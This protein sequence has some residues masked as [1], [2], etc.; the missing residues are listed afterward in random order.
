MQDE[1]L[2]VFVKAPQL[3]KVKTRLAK[4]IGPEAAR[5]AYSRLVDVLLQNLSTLAR[6][7]LRVTP[8]DS[9]KE[10]EHWLRDT[11]AIRPQGQGSL[12]QRLETAFSESFREGVARVVIIGSDC[13][14]LQA[15]DIEKSWAALKSCD[16]VLGPA[17][18]G[19]YWLI[20]LNKPRA[21]LFKEISWS[22][23]TVLS[24]TL[25]RANSAGLKVE[26]LDERS[27]VDTA[28]DWN[29]FLLGKL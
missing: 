27:D 20:G 3:G 15:K 26:L 28:G 6:V 9:N 7:Q 14:T 16:V 21:A 13:P 5:S 19:G 17:R 23:D 1:L 2:I 12:G 29:R 25:V 10:I 8:D 18:D 4:E 11:W 24:E 22:T